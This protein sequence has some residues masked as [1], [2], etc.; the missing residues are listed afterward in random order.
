MGLV[1]VG[2]NFL[3]FFVWFLFVFY[4]LFLVLIGVSVCVRLWFDAL[5][6]LPKV[7]FNVAQRDV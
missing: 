2:K 3:R 1:W 4:G 7:A 6:M 5:S